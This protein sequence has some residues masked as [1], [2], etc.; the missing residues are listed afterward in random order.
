MR[1]TGHDNTNRLQF[2][3]T[4]ELMEVVVKARATA[5]LLTWARCFTYRLRRGHVLEDGIHCRGSCARSCCQGRRHPQR[6]ILEQDR[7]EHVSTT[8]SDREV[9]ITGGIPGFQ[10]LCCRPKP[11]I[12]LLSSAEVYSKAQL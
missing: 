11:V 12:V 2:C 8:L 10:E 3:T 1:M 5:K 7:A 6:A 4:F 9:L